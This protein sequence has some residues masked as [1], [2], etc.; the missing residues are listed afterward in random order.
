MAS[1]NKVII[2]G[3]LGRDPETRQLPSGGQVTNLAVATSRSYTNKSNNERVEETEWHRIAVFGKQAESCER[4]LAKGRQVYVEGRLKTTSYEKDG[5]KRYS[6][7]IVADVVQFLGGR[8]EGDA[9]PVQESGRS[10]SPSTSNASS[11]P[12][13]D[14]DIPF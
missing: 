1:V 9:R 5:Q 10:P 14:D 3:N 2:V 7:D 4:Y 11:A 8:A 6:T 13:Y 12:S